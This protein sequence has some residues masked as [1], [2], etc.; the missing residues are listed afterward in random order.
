MVFTL[1]WVASGFPG[2]AEIYALLGC[3]TLFEV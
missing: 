2:V 1:L 3:F